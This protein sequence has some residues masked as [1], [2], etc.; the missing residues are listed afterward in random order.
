MTLIYLILI[1]GNKVAINSDEIQMIVDG[2]KGTEV[3]LK[4]GSNFDNYTT[5]EETFQEVC[6]IIPR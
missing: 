4:H 6:K 5:V 1:G 3:W 2:S